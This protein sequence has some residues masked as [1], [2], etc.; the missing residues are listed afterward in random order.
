MI[1]QLTFNLNEM[2]YHQRLAEQSSDTGLQTFHLEEA[3]RYRAEARRLES[4]VRVARM[5]ISEWI[6]LN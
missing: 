3:L 2:I 5:M 1:D 6:S 4:Q